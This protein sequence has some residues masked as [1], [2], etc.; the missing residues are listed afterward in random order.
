MSE[1]RLTVT[2]IIKEHAENIPDKIA[3]ILDDNSLSFG[4]LYQRI[5]SVTSFLLQKGVKRGSHVLSMARPD[6]EFVIFMYAVLGIGAVHIPAENRI[7]PE[8]LKEIAIAVDADVILS[9]EKPECDCFWV[10][11]LEVNLEQEYF[12]WD[13]VGVSDDCCEI[14]FTTGT[15]G[16][17]KGVMLSSRG[18]ETY[19]HVMNL[20]FQLDEESV[21]LLTTPLNHV[22]G[23]HRIHQCMAAGSTLIL[24]EGIRNLRAIFSV[25]NTHGVTHTYLPPASVK[26]LITLAKN[27]LAKLDG[28][29]KFIYTASAPFPVADIET[30]IDILPNTR[31]YQGYGSSETGSISYC[32]YNA[33]GESVDCLG[34]PHSC[35]EV[36]LL[37]ADEYVIDEAYKVG[38]IC[39]KSEMNMLG[40]YKEPELTACV[41]KDEFI[42]SNDLMFFD[43]HGRLYFAGRGGDVINVKGFKVSPIEVENCA[44]DHP[45]IDECIC[46]PYDD[47]LQGTVV[48]MLVRLNEGYTL[49]TEELISY[50]SNKLEIYKVPKYIEQIDQIKRTPN[51]KIDRVQMIEQYSNL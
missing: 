8:R 34:E 46:I 18:L 27:D 39:S 45:A 41:L 1:K 19:L 12:E 37:D 48:K 14:I 2:G 24:M 15:T 3:I 40:Y 30:L 6:M 11:P 47:H 4:E 44:M 7:P 35:V 28:K 16:K 13:P 32:C 10:N 51:G 17:S 36:K 43:E 23:L 38:F 26:F 49:D 31:L 50:F 22:G 20:S 29:L 25:I 33:S 5:N 42:H 9:T 21:F